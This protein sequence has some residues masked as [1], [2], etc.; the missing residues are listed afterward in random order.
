MVEYTKPW[1]SL[2]QQVEQLASSGVEV[3]DRDRAAALL[4]A[5]G[6]YRL[7]G[8]LYPFRKSESYLSGDGRTRT[9]VLCRAPGFGG[10]VRRRGDLDSGL[11]QDPADRLDPVI[12]LVGVDVVDDHL[13]L[14]SSSAAAKNAEAVF[15]ISLARRSSRFSR[16]SSAMRFASSVVVPGRTPPGTAST[17]NQRSWAG[18]RTCVTVPRVQSLP[19]SSLWML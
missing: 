12:G 14:R 11:A 7:S 6:Y 13:S 8:Y 9:R 2:E 3:G 18:V 5:V 4:K 15:R 10:V 19:C 16:S 1:L 17:R